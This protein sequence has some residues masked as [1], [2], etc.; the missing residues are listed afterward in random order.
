M[1]HSRLIEKMEE[2]TYSG[3]E[4]GK[5]YSQQCCTGNMTTEKSIVLQCLI[6]EYSFNINTMMVV[7][8]TSRNMIGAKNAIGL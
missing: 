5:R 1:S 6:T 4:T 2:G 7:S 3:G 8:Y